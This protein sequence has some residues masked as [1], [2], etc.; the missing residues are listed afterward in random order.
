MKIFFFLTLFGLALPAE[1]QG[2]KKDA[3]VE[4][5][6]ECVDIITNLET[7]LTKA[8]DQLIKEIP[9]DF[10]KS[11]NTWVSYDGM[12]QL[13]IET[14]TWLHENAFIIREPRLAETID[15]LNESIEKRGDTFH[16]DDMSEILRV[17]FW[18]RLQGKP[19][20]LDDGLKSS[21][22]YWREW[23][24][25][26]IR[27]SPLGRGEIKWIWTL[28]IPTRTH[29][30]MHVGLDLAKRTFVCYEHG[31]GLYFPEGEV[32]DRINREIVR[33]SDLALDEWKKTD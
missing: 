19:I 28:Q 9:E 21:V 16:G 14:L 12:F 1:A 33:N 13:P 5:D 31:L 2:Q 4:F 17:S 24:V 7:E 22:L 23:T 20:E 10:K 6:A 8:H 25:P 29:G 11:L 30:V 15:K 3:T 26:E 27:F 18:N 32:M